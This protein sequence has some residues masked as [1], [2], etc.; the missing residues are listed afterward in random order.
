VFG[1]EEQAAYSR[2]EALRRERQ[3]QRETGVT[4][5]RWAGRAPVMLVPLQGDLYR[6][7]NGQST[8]IATGGVVDPKL[9]RDGRRAF[10]VR[11][12]ELFVVD[13]SGERQL[14]DGAEPGLSHGLAEYIAQE[15]LARHTGYW[16]SPDGERVAYEEADE[17]HIPVYP[18]V[19]Q[20]ADLP[21]VEEHRYPFAG[22]ANANVRLGVVSTGGGE[23]RWLLEVG[24]AYLARVNWHPDGRLFVQL[25]SRDQR[26]VDLYAYDAYGA[27]KLLLSEVTEPWVN[28]QDDLRFVEATGEFLWSSERS[29]FRH[30]YLY[31]RDGNLVRQLTAG[32]LPVDGV[33]ALDQKHRIVYFAAARPSAVERRICGVSLDGGDVAELTPEAGTHSATFAP[34]CSSFVDT[35][36]SLTQ[37][38][39]VTV[40]RLDGASWHVVHAPAA[41]DLDLPAPELRTLINRDGTL[42]HAALYHPSDGNRPAPLIVSV[43]GG[44]HAQTVKDAWLTT[45]DLRAQYLAAAGFLVLKVDNRGSARRGLAFEAPIA[46]DM[47]NVELRDQVDG[48]RW[49]CQQGLADAARVGIYGWSYG[50]YMSAMALVKAPETFRVGVAGAPVTSWDGYDTG[51]TERYM[52][53]PATNAEGYRRAA[54][55]THVDRLAGKL[56]L[57]HGMIDENVHFRHTARLVHALIAANKPHDLLIYPAERHMP[58]READRVAME[59]RIVEYFQRHL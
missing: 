35:Y 59:T 24:D 55:L 13:A 56:L 32:D 44:P 36:E 2:E 18:I 1:A 54:V 31:D 37:P 49:A 17:R 9:S 4:D 15:E 26:R 10:F 7:E 51:Y 39:S 14:S 5:Y 43:Y 27:R 50:G 45:V 42:L 33:S 22:A 25:L 30:L 53:T 21:E 28:L 3:R 46:G 8:R 52:Q 48:A 6:V 16:P 20:A 29:G 12:G 11:A 47:G 41:V 40:R 58:R 38:P 19:H 23:T 34:D 57:V